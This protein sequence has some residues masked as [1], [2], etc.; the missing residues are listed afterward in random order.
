MQAKIEQFKTQT[1][2]DL[3]N[4]LNSKD[5]PAVDKAAIRKALQ[6]KEP[7]TEEKKKVVKKTATAKAVKKEPT[8]KKAVKKVVKK[9]ATKKTSTKKVEAK[10]KAEPKQTAKPKVKK[11]GVIATIYNTICKKKCTEAQILAILV[12][13]FPDKKAES[14]I[15]TIKTQIGTNKRPVRMEREKNINFKIEEKKKVKYY[16]YG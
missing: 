4:L 8:K 12:K 5:T 2:E 10:K 3:T 14:M 1:I 13:D 9:T 11:V 7:K 16:S 6:S 15:K